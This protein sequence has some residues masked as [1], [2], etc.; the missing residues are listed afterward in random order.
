M[1]S[2]NF[3]SRRHSMLSARSQTIIQFWEDIMPCDH[4]VQR[5]AKGENLRRCRDLHVRPVLPVHVRQPMRDAI[6]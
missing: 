5:R 4:V 1:V 3:L 6:E 2:R